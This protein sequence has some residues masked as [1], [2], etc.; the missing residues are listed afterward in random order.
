[1]PE[2]H[3][4]ARLEPFAVGSGFNAV[5]VK[6][7]FVKP[8]P[9]G[10]YIAMVFRVVGYGQDCD[11]SALVEVECVDQHGEPTGW[12]SNALGL[13]ADVDVVLDGPGDLHDLI[14]GDG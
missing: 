14:D 8:V 10:T 9:E 12:G 1:M 5:T 3:T 7:D 13:H 2:P 4:N 6:R 11:G